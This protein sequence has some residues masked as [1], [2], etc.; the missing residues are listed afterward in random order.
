M[1]EHP[2]K[3]KKNPLLNRHLLTFPSGGAVSAQ[4]EPDREEEEASVI[5]RL[6]G[7]YISGCVWIELKTQ[8]RL[9][10]CDWI[11]VSNWI[12][13]V[14]FPINNSVCFD[15]LNFFSPLFFSFFLHI[16]CSKW[17]R[18]SVGANEYWHDR[19][20]ASTCTQP[21]AA[22]CRWW[23][24]SFPVLLPA[25]WYAVAQFRFEILPRCIAPTACS[26]WLHASNSSRWY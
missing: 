1:F 19:R 6:M 4:V 20:L 18:L 17:Q 16:A 12:H 13:S 5:L 10:A 22:F 8:S 3:N 9:G 21:W 2:R 14:D 11:T 24:G 7:V 25:L 23:L 26:K 15:N